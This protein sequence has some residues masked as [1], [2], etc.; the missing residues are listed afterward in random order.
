M[1]QW[2]PIFAQLLR[3]SVAAYYDIETTFPVGDAPRLADFVLL[4][5]TARVTPPF[6]GL[7]QHLTVW[8]ILEFKGPSVSPRHGDVELLIELGLGI[9]RRLRRH[10]G[11][12]GVR[13]EPVSFSYL[14]N[15]LGR[16]FLADVERKLGPLE[17]LGSG[18]WRCRLLGRVLLWVSSID[19]P[20]EK[21]S[22][23]L[24]IVG[25][26]PPATELQ[27]ARLVSEH[28]DLQQLYGG[29]VFSLHPAAWKEVEAMARASGKAL[30]IDLRPAIEHLGLRRVIDQV[31]LD[32][33]IEEYGKNE[34][35]E[36]IGEKEA[37]KRI[38]IERWLSHL[39]PAERR[40]LK[41]RLE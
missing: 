11:Q 16:R 25:R 29:W 14:A 23:P 4:R 1:K 38:G 37:V 12:R 36:R 21:D 35:I 27:V 41:R 7:W 30:Q 5:R 9:E 6:H 28:A 22:L 18:L 19:L 13:P 8:N 24:H 3:P 26:E 2:H 32:R 40:E 39:S 20:V 31:G 17:A 15:H 33:V 10:R 34:V